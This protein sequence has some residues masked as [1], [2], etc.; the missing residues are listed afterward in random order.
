MNICF[1]GVDDRIACTPK[2]FI[3]IKTVFCAPQH[4]A[5]DMSSFLWHNCRTDDSSP[6]QRLW[7][8][9]ECDADQ[10][11][12]EL[13]LTNCMIF[14]MKQMFMYVMLNNYFVSYCQNSIGFLAENPKA[15]ILQE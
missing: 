5:V 3:C 4:L 14:K 9:N 1:I 2:L 8:Q 11:R 10:K 6:F 15:N 7:L 12:T 13:T